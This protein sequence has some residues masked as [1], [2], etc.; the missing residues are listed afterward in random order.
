MKKEDP[1]DFEE[2]L[3][4]PDNLHELLAIRLRLT[5]GVCL[6]DFKRVPKTTLLTLTSL[7]EE[8][9]LH[10]NKD[11]FSLTEKGKLFYDSVASELV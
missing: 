8:G 11:H 1:K 2:H 5:T 7:A 6:S 3:T 10:Q 4:Y 9:F